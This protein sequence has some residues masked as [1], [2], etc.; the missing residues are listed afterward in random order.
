MCCILFL[1]LSGF[2]REAKPEL[3]YGEERNPMSCV[4]E[5]A[6]KTDSNRA[7]MFLVNYRPDLYPDSPRLGLQA[8]MKYGM[9]RMINWRRSLNNVC[10]FPQMTLD[11]RWNWSASKTHH[12]AEESRRPASRA[13]SGGLIPCQT[14]HQHD[15]QLPVYRGT[16]K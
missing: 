14:Q 15:A 13:K 9:A 2:E 4:F 8:A 10:L 11:R 7:L 1:R 3:N 12:H 5:I 16:H 6:A